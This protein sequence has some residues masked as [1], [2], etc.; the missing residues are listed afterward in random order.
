VAEMSQGFFV[1][2]FCSPFVRRPL[3]RCTIL[4]CDAQ[5]LC[6]TAQFHSPTL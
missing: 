3:L 1:A 5:S 4:C 2:L 6:C